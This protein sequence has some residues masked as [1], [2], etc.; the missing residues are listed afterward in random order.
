MRPPWIAALGFVAERLNGHRIEWMLV[1]SAATALRGVG[2]VPGDIDIAVR[3][4]VDVE[5]AAAV[6]PMPD[7][8]LG[9]G[10]DPADWVSTAPEPV[11]RFGHAMERWTFGKWMVGGVKVELAHID[12]PEVAGLMMETRAPLVWLERETVDCLGRAVPT[13]PIEVQLATMVARR[14]DARL[15][16]T[17]AALD[18]AAVNVTL[19]RRAMSDRRVEAP[20]L[21]VPESVRRLLDGGVAGT[22]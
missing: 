18:P 16:A 22:G 10:G 17:I 4:A 19:L 8:P 6:L 1:G 12:A 11:L 20:D 3:E 9:E 21:V 2:I 14:Q 5:G 13:V 7:G 15:R